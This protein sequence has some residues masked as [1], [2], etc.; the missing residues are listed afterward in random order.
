MLWW[1]FYQTTYNVQQLGVL[2]DQVLCEKSPRFLKKEHQKDA[3]NAISKE[4]R[5]KDSTE[6]EKEFTKLREKYN[7]YK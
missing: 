1:K 3:W 6:V 2:F 7:K 5:L 4:L